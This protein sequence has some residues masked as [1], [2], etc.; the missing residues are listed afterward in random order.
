[1]KIVTIFLKTNFNGI[2][3][4][5]ESDWINIHKSNFTWLEESIAIKLG[6]VIDAGS[7]KIGCCLNF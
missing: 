3:T 5:S 4:F 7:I 1:M 2:I 6:S